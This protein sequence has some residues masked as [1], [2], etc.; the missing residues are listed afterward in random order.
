MRD[1]LSI[2]NALS[3]RTRL[4]LIMSLRE[5]ELCAC[6]LIEVVGLAAST[7]SKHMYLLRHASLVEMRKEGRWVYYRLAGRDVPIP[8]RRAIKW[9]TEAMADD[10]QIIKDTKH[11]S[12]ILK[13]KPEDLCRRQSQRSASSSSA[14]ATRV[15]AKWQRDGRG[16]SNHTR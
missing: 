14:P 16:T 4:R 8:A 12:K 13:S 7:V 6:Q 15:A 5:G 1:I 2:T 9:V 10:P 11:L 3:D